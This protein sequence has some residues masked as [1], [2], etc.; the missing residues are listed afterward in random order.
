MSPLSPHNCSTVNRKCCYPN[1]SHPIFKISDTNFKFVIFPW[2]SWEKWFQTVNVYHR[3]NRAL[4]LFWCKGPNK[5]CVGHDLTY[6]NQMCHAFRSLLKA[7]PCQVVEVRILHSCHPLKL[8][9][10]K[11]C[12]KTFLQWEHGCAQAWLY[13]Q[14]SLFA[15]HHLSGSQQEGL[16]Q[17]YKSLLEPSFWKTL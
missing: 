3:S 7:L 6:M 15:Q 4:W 5:P 11:C 1:P 17:I 9:L 12:Y 13:P 2:V 10:F 8:V 16:G 14:D